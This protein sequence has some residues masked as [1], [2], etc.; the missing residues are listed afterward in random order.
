MRA[1]FSCKTGIGYFDYITSFLEM[2]KGIGRLSRKNERFQ[3]MNM[4]T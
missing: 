3:C 4:N 2:G 1:N